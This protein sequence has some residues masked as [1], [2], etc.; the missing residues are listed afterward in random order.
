METITKT[1]VCIECGSPFTPDPAHPRAKYCKRACFEERYRRVAEYQR[2]RKLLDA[3]EAALEQPWA[4]SGAP[5][6]EPHRKGAD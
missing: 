3:F 2:R 1:T 6:K 5:G 4:L